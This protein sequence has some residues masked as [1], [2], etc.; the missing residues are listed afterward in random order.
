L[1][2]VD[3]DPLLPPN[4]R[5]WVPQDHLVDFILDAVV[6]LDLKAV[7]V[8]NFQT[9]FLIFHGTALIPFYMSSRLR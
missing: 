1:F 7:K 9:L 6:A 2:P 4:L 3:R 5:D 8:K